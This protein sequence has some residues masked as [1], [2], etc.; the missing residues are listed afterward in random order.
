MMANELLIA[1]LRKH[2]QLNGKLPEKICECCAEDDQE[3]LCIY[4]VHHL[5]SRGYSDETC[6]LCLN[7]HRKVTSAQ[8][9]MI[10]LI[11]DEPKNVRFRYLYAQRSHIALRKCMDDFTERYNW[12]NQEMV[13]RDG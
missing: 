7:C 12:W 2:L 11:R 6:V 5:H 9:R 10:R 4:E 8:N 13:L 3:V 1:Q